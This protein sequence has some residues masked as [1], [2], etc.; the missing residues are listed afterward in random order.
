MPAGSK[1][2]AFLLLLFLT[3]PVEAQRQKDPVAIKGILDLREL[4]PSGKFAVNLKGEWEFYWKRFFT[5]SDFKGED[6]PSPDLY[7]KVP[8]YWTEYSDRINVTPDGF[9]TYRLIVLLPRSYRQ[10]MGF[11][12][13]VFDSSFELWV[14][15]S[16]FYSNGRPGTEP[17]TEQPGY[18]PGFRRFTPSSDTISIL[19]N[20]S[21]FN[22]RR[23][24]FWRPMTIGSFGTIQK[25][26]ASNWALN[27]SV[28]GILTAFLLFFFIFFML[29]PRDKT[30]LS[31]SIALLGLAIRPLFNGDYLI[32]DFADL[33]WT[34]TIRFEYLSAFITLAGWIWY[35]YHLYPV[36]LLKI[37]A[38]GLTIF[39]L[40]SAALTLT[41]P[42]RIFSYSVMVAYTGIAVLAICGIVFPIRG[43]IRKNTTDLLYLILFLF[44]IAGSV[45][46]VQVSLGKIQ[47]RTGYIIPVV[48]VIFIFLQS[49][50]II[51][52]WVREFHENER[53]RTK[54]EFLNR[55][56]EDIVENRTRELQS[57][58][59][60]VER[61]N[62][63]IEEQN[64]KLTETVNLKNR[65]FSVIAHDLRSPVV[66]ILYI[67]NLL[68]DKEYK[69]HYDKFAESSI[70]YA[71]MVINLLENMLVWG[72]GQEEKLNY[73]P[74]IHDL[75]SVI[76]TNMSI[77]KEPA[78][79][80]NISINFTQK[81]KPN[82]FFDKD[83]IDIVIR[84]LI[85]NAVKY[86]GRGGRISIL[87]KE[88]L[89]AGKSIVSVC[90]N[91]IGMTEEMIGRIFSSDEI[92][93]IPGTEN[94][95]GTGIGLRLCLDLLR[96]NNGELTIES[97][98]GEGSC[99]RII[100]PLRPTANYPSNP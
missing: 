68:R 37:L 51:Y 67:L 2:T 28:V 42:V 93:S 60:E 56:L 52:R 50:L 13:P 97:R 14:N 1:L 69:E 26:K 3:L 70:N 99:F 65:L 27:Y 17:G 100:L 82:A 84:N 38:S 7:A 49:V 6:K 21:N 33:S 46:D 15:D 11:D 57:R 79:R 25:S 31:F 23:G 94:E 62:K 91:G 78:D 19:I 96:I 66:S 58:T 64:I 59:E 86:T 22:H 9:A 55:N 47:G 87:L 29:Y 75:S 5:P 40:A 54:L 35:L 44:L 73:S 95:K 45:H 85:S 74:A 72:R 4:N 98:P 32:Y 76:L 43:L 90:D 81:G 30:M 92:K 48:M 16:L 80:K 24:G 83:L 41:T 53:L 18:R 36:R 10:S 20:V 61:K 77:F 71:Q 89:A 8:A 12:I 88:D 63:L 39:Y 34:W